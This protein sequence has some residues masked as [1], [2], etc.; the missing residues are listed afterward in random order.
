MDFEYLF[1][2]M[3]GRRTRLVYE[4]TY[5]A[6]VFTFYN[7]IPH[8]SKIKELY[9]VSY[10]ETSSRRM[11]EIYKSLKNE[12]PQL[13]EI[14]KRMKIIKIGNTRDC[15]YGMLYEF[16]KSGDVEEELKSLES[17]LSTLPNDAFLMIRGLYLIPA[18]HGKTVLGEILRLF[19]AIPDGITLLDYYSAG[20]LDE[21]LN[22]I[23]EKLYDVIIGIR[24]DDAIFGDDNF[25]LSIDQSIIKGLEPRSWRVK[26]GYEG[27]VDPTL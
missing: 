1:Q 27:I 16:I 11:G 25:I 5:A 22:R 24:K 20:I 7:I 4:D 19:D 21:H 15:S 23:V 6:M 10:S 14:F 9:V 12:N 3:D 2:K 18:I 26:I 13:A 17:V 8:F